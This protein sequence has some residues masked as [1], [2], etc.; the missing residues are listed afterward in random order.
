MTRPDYRATG[1]EKIPGALPERQI[2]SPVI[3]LHLAVRIARPGVRSN[4]DLVEGRL[5]YIRNGELDCAA[6]AAVVGARRRTADQ[7]VL[8]VPDLDAG[9][10][11]VVSAPAL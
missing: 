2:E 3:R 1:R 5:G 6:R 9:V 7:L 8:L 10:L 11:D 4:G